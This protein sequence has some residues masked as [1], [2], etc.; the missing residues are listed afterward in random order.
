MLNFEEIKNKRIFELTKG[1][2]LY[3]YF[4]LEKSQSE[5]AKLLNTDSSNVSRKFKKESIFASRKKENISKSQLQNNID[6][7]K[8]ILENEYPLNSITNI[9]KKYG[10]SYSFVYKKLKEYNIPIQK[11]GFFQKKYVDNLNYGTL[12]NLYWIE[13]LSMDEIGI[14]FK[15]DKNFIKRRLKEFNIKIRTKKESFN[16]PKHKERKREILKKLIGNNLTIF[17]PVYNIKAIKII[18][19]FGKKMGFNFLHAENGGEFFIDK[20]FYWLDGYDIDKNVV[21]EYYEKNHKYKKEYDD[22]RILEIKKF[23]KCKIFIIHYD[24]TIEEL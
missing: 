10:I 15:T 7:T 8:E 20:L 19:D 18:E 22:L 24:N 9:A 6:L 13:N 14:I 2:L 16:L 12:Y 5:I 3:L 21:V 1:E 23:L 4:D 11:N 17:K